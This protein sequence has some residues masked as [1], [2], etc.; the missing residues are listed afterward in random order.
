MGR[1]TATLEELAVRVNQ[2]LGLVRRGRFINLEFLLGIGD[3]AHF[4]RIADGQLVSVTAGPLLLR[5]WRFAIH[6]E[7]DAWGKFCHG[8]PSPG[9]HDLFAMTKLGVARIEGEIHPF[10]AN[11]RY[12]KELLAM[13]RQGSHEAAHG[14]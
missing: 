3:E 7:D 5:P 13:A 1:V 14:R 9:Y 10:M 12:F 11:L 8:L 2:N 6:I 4:L